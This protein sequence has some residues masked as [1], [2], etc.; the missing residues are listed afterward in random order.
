MFLGT[1][2]T[3]SVT[4]YSIERKLATVSLKEPERGL[5][6]SLSDV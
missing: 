1:F 2:Q 4:G 6:V 3:L 5:E